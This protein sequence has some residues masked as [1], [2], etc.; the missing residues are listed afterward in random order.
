M[1]F[2]EKHVGLI[3]EL[4]GFCCHLHDMTARLHLVS[5]TGRQRQAA[6][7]GPLYLNDKTRALSI[8]DRDD[9]KETHEANLAQV[10]T[11]R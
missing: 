3:V 1:G 9:H 8:I 2:G 5:T 4:L 6:S 10:F 11:T 7:H